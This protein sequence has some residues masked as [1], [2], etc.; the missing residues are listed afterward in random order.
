MRA[1]GHNEQADKFELI[2]G[3][4]LKKQEQENSE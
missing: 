4:I 3:E 2:I 1:N